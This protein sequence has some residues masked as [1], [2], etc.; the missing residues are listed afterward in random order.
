MIPWVHLDTAKAPGGGGELRLSRRGS[1]FSI[2]IGQAELMNSRLSGSEKALATLAFEKI[3]DRARPR[4]L[5]G[6]LGMGFTLG[7]ALEVLP[8]GA[9]VVVA[10]LVPAVV[11][12]ARGPMAEIFGDSLSDPRVTIVEDDVGAVIR[13]GRGGYD[14]ILLDVD[15]GPEGMTRASNDGLYGV[16]GLGDARAALKPGGVLAV[17]SQGP[18]KAFGARLFKSGFTTEEHRVRAHRAGKGARHVIW[19][20]TK[21]EAGARRR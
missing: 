15:N 19:I 21:G 12:W 3:S 13:A 5:I 14:A 18:D 7:A 4:M 20:A 11:A 1:E 8:A 10:E 9:S 2:R 6:G 17:W 16:E